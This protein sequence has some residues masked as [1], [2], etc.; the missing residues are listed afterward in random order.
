MLPDPTIYSIRLKNLSLCILVKLTS[1]AS[2]CQTV[3]SSEKNE[4]VKWV[5]M[6]MDSTND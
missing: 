4:P 3:I 5:P 6:R 1:E 2:F